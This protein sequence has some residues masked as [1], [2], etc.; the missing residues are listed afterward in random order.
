[1]N[2][3]DDVFNC[4]VPECGF[5]SDHYSEL[6]EV[7]GRGWW[8]GPKLFCSN[9]AEAIREGDL[10]RSE[11]TASYRKKRDPDHPSD[12][13]QM[14]GGPRD[15]RGFPPHPDKKE[16]EGTFPL[17][18]YHAMEK[19]TGT[20]PHDGCGFRGTLINYTGYNCPHMCPECG[21]IVLA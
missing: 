4:S 20:C 16:T 14:S 8:Q 11:V 5:G 13:I 12:F 21:G 17:D 10:S 9:H 7:P 3:N 6:E 15:G 18:D 1:M 2:D 19:L